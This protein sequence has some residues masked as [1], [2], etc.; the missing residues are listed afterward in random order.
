MP[1]FCDANVSVV[2][3][4]ETVPACPVPFS[5]TVWVVG[6]AL[7][8]SVK[9]PVRAPVPNGVNSMGIVQVEPGATE[10][11]ETNDGK[12]KSF[13]FAP[14]NVSLEIVR[15]LSPVLLTVT[16]CGALC[17]FTV[18]LGKLSSDGES[19]MTG[20]VA[21]PV[22]VNVNGPPAESVYTSWAVRLPRAIGLKSIEI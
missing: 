6:D 19:V 9:T 8:F 22:N 4:T 3:V 20:P 2:G 7:V 21:V 10:K 5:V 13:P 14:V 11:H 17:V 1:T 16:D 12:E 18:W 15:I